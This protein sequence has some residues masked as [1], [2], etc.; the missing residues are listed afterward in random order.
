MRPIPVALLLLSACS[1]QSLK[2]INASPTAEIVSHEDGSEALEGY[3][4]SLRGRASDPDHPVTDLMGVWRVEGEEACPAQAADEVGGLGCDVVF[5]EGESIVTL[6]I[7]DPK[8]A[9]GSDIVELVVIPTEAPT[10]TILSPLDGQRGY[11]DTKLRLEGLIQDAEETPD[12][13]TAVWESDIDGVL[14]LDTTADPSGLMLAF[15]TLSEGEHALTLEVED[16]SGRTGRDAVL[17]TVGPPNSAPSCAITA[18]VD[19]EV[20][21]LGDGVQLIGQVDDADI[22]PDALNVTWSSD[23]DGALGGSVPDSSGRVSLNAAALSAGTHQLSLQAMD[24]LGEVCTAGVSLRVSQAPK[25]AISTPASGT[26]ANE[27]QSLTFTAIVSDAEDAPTALQLSWASDRDGVFATAGADS[28]GLSTTLVSSLSPGAHVATVTVT[29]TDGLTATAVV[30]LTVN[31]LP[32]APTVSISP[33]SPR[34]DDTLTV[35]IDA[36]STDAEGDPITYTYAWL[37][38][39]V[40]SSASTGATL[41]P[42]ATTRGQ[43][44]TVKVTPSDGKGSGTSAAASAVIQ[45]SLPTVSGLS[46]STSTPRTNDVIVATVG[47]ADADGDAVSLSYVWTVNGAT[48]PVT[49]SSLDGALY[50]SKGDRVQ[51]VVTPNDG[52][53]DGVPLTGAS[54]L[55]LNTQPTAPTARVSPSFPAFGEDDLVCGV[56]KASTDDD[57]D[58][59]SYIA[60]W[61]V[62]GVDYASSADTGP[63]TSGWTG[64]R[65]TTWTDDTVPMADPQEGEVWTCTMTPDDGEDFGPTSS[66]SVTIDCGSGTCDIDYS[67]NWTLSKTINYSCAYGIV[68]ISFSEV[69][70]IDLT[71]SLSITSTSS[72][73]PGT[74]VGSFT[75]DV[76]FSVV[77]TIPSAICTETYTMTGTFNSETDFTAKL[78]GSYSGSLCFDCTGFTRNFTG[79]R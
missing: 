55:V 6:E 13:L 64:P 5:S 42:S 68:S 1:D 52:V 77:E 30:S 51:L 35:S 70:I 18:P 26:Q 79:T 54:V 76:D 37:V 72:A 45:N 15:T 9:T 7:T 63:D 12:Q 78:V 17:I 39:G 41:P 65:S 22:G 60:T 33:T 71:S 4:V 2:S 36:P 32:T 21:V 74:M 31:G 56:T 40:A 57:G 50:F 43:T 8:G 29:D 11:S 28:A 66:H 23:R 62:D 25:V 58:T 75:S 10:A 38:D 46:L 59:L 19:G 44:W 16:S 49:G 34:T 53:S 69:D 48:M 27:A 3:V 61:L 14:D 67:D 47:S 24:E 20:I 73:R